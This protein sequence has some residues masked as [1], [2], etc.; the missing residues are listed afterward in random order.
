[1]SDLLEDEL[2]LEVEREENLDQLMDSLQEMISDREF[3]IA[4]DKK[5]VQEIVDVRTQLDDGIVAENLDRSIELKL[6]VV[7]IEEQ[8]VDD[9]CE[10]LDDLQDLLEE[11]RD[12]ADR[13][14]RA[15][16]LFSQPPESRAAE[17]FDWKDVEDVELVLQQ[18]ASSVAGEKQT[19]RELSKSIEDALVSR[20]V[21]LGE[22]MPPGLAK[23]AQG[24]ALRGIRKALSLPEVDFSFDKVED[25][26]AEKKRSIKKAL[27]VSNAGLDINPEDIR[28]LRGGDAKELFSKFAKAVG[29]KGKLGGT[30]RTPNQL[31]SRRDNRQDY[32]DQALARQNYPNQQRPSGVVDKTKAAFQD[33]K[34]KFEDTLGI[35]GSRNQPDNSGRALGRDNQDDSG[36]WDFPRR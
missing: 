2:E 9:L 13:A 19:I 7:V 27:R 20:A 6:N 16:D 12:R 8:L 21:V 25:F 3:S 1:M 11:A 4:N 35:P 17:S 30:K 24:S 22:I 34:D 26:L 5:I 29:L 14:D 36:P 28:D 10:C 15:M 23:T 18:A 33:L 32:P 31:P